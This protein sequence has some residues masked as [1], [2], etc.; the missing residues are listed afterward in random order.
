MQ[1]PHRLADLLTCPVCG[2]NN[3]EGAKFCMECAAVLRG[4]APSR[5]VRTLGRATSGWLAGP[6]PF[7][8][9]PFVMLIA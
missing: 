3:P 1:G 4:T 6:D 7:S 9:R 5:E 8:L 2:H